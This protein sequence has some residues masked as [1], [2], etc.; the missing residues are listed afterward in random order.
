VDPIAS[1]VLPLS[2]RR[3]LVVEDI[4][5]IADDVRRTLSKAGALVVGPASSTA[6]AIRAIDGEPIDAAVLDVNLEGEMSYPVALE[7]ERRAIP[8]I[9]ASGYDDWAVPK[10]WQHVPRLEK[11]YNLRELPIAVAAL[12]APPQQEQAG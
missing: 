5:F 10:E 12:F 1:S 4:Y 3:V 2:G 9:F 8:F 6:D 11:P 7:L